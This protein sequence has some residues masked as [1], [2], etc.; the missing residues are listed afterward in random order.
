MILLLSVLALTCSAADTA[1]QA[2]GSIEGYNDQL[3][4]ELKFL[5]DKMKV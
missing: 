1:E 4:V 5:E 3:D 2:L